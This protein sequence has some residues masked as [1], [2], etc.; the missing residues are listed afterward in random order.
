MQA[1][2]NIL[3]NVNVPDLPADV[4]RGARLATQGRRQYNNTFDV[5]QDEQGDTCCRFGGAVAGGVDIPGSDI[6]TVAEGYIAVT[7]FTLDYTNGEALGWLQE[8]W[9]VAGLSWE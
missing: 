5:W 7:P 1:P 6:M 4:I 2:A 8:R 3:L 9:P